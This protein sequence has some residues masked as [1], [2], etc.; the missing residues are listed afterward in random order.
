LTDKW[1]DKEYKKSVKDRQKKA[2]E[3]YQSWTNYESAK[4]YGGSVYSTRQQCNFFYFSGIKF[5]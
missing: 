3:D 2:K 5:V 1:I 4:T